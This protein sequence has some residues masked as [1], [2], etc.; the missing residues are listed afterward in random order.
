[1]YHG[2]GTLRGWKRALPG[3][4]TVATRLQGS[5]EVLG[6]QVFRLLL[7]SNRCIAPKRNPRKGKV[8]GAYKVYMLG[9]WV[10]RG[11]V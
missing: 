10:S 7:P 9:A 1:M 8:V 11:S 2:Q 3:L 4:D 5:M 6:K